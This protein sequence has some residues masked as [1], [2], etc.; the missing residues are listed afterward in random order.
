MRR[1]AL[2]PLALLALLVLTATAAAGQQ[3]AEVRRITLGPDG[4]PYSPAVQVDNTIWLSGMVGVSDGRLVAGGI[5]AETRQTLENIRSTLAELGATMDDVVKCTVF[6]VD[7]KEWAA[8]NE[9]YATFFPRHKPARSALGVAGLPFDARI[10][11]EC[12][13]VLGAGVR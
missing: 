3:A 13:A 4:P 2:P 11:I 10:E 8:L 12:M 7:I 6:L 5:Q 1:R 9:V